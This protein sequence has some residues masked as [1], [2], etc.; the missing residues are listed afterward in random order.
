M[1]ES[2]NPH[3]ARKEV[4]PGAVM[5]TDGGARVIGNASFTTFNL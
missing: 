1:N 5:L 3:R 2:H 4:S